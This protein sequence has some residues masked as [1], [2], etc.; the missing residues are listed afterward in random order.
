MILYF[1]RHGET[2][3]N[4]KK[5]IQGKTDIPLNENGL[6]QARTLA[7]HLVQ[8]QFQVA[9]AYTSPQLRAAE[10]AQIAADALGVECVSMSGLR[11]MDMGDWEGSNWDTIE[12]TYG[13]VYTYWDEHRRYTHTP[14]GESY[15]EVLGRTLMTLKEIIEQEE[16]D[17]LIVTHSAVL[18]ALRCY[19]AEKPF[20][21]M[22][23]HFKTRNAEVVR[24]S[25]EEVKGAITR[26]EA[27]E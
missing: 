24:I 19:L 17:V 27:G 15:D 8:E 9:C 25:A 22:V 10:T 23:R 26:Y 4:V 11:E 6:K 7:G 5:K 12:E 13:E 20:G 18:M 16:Q 1:V 14:G 21:E 2:E 3:W